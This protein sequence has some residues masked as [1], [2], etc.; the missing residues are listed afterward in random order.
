MTGSEC[1]RAGASSLSEP[2]APHDASWRPL[3]PWLGAAA[4]LIMALAALAV[5]L[6]RERQIGLESARL[7]AV[8]AVQAQQVTRWVDDHRGQF[9][10]LARTPLWPELLL[11]WQDQGD[12]AA[13]ERLLERTRD[14][15]K[16]YRYAAVSVIDAA[17][18]VL[19]L[20]DATPPALT[21]ATRDAV[22]RAAATGQ[23]AMSELHHALGDASELRLDFVV[24][25]AAPGVRGASAR[26]LVVVQLDP[27]LD[28]L[29]M[30]AAW[31]D[32]RAP[33]ATQLVQRSGDMLV[34]PTAQNPV[35]LSRPGLLAGQVVRGELAPGV[36]HFADDLDGSAVLGVVRPVPGTPWWLV[37]RVQREDVMAPVW[38]SA[39]WAALLSLVGLAMAP[40]A[41]RARSAGATRASA[42][43]RGGVGQQ[44][45]RRHLGQR[46][47]RPLHHLQPGRVSPHR[48]RRGRGDRTTRQRVVRCHHR[49]TVR[50]A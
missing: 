50:S 7:E 2:A 43:A 19:P 26:W 11:R 28:L 40:R 42:V 46:P 47:G 33:A 34:G 17:G 39:R 41:R 32:S 31:P 20:A 16:G 6:A 49:G 3:L 37:S 35:P 25:M 12:D 48:P 15:A 27:R 22:R 4:A 44:L 13:R 1:R 9:Q 30:L 24:P 10:F 23:P 36:A 29:P 45:A 8:A 21:A 14:Y 18:H 5:W 38:D